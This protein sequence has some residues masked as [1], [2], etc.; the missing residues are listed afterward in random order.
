MATSSCVCKLL[1]FPWSSK[2]TMPVAGELH[3]AIYLT[4]SFIAVGLI[5]QRR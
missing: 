2:D 4:L 5:R 1:L 3:Q